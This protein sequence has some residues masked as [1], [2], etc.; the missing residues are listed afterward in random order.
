M[1]R[2]NLSDLKIPITLF[3]VAVGEK[4]NTKNYL[5]SN[6]IPEE[7]KYL[8]RGVE[9]DL[10]KITEATIFKVDGEHAVATWEVI[11][12]TPDGLVLHTWE[13]GGR[14][15]LVEEMKISPDDYMPSGCKPDL[16][17]NKHNIQKSVSS[18]AKP[19]DYIVSNSI[20][21]H[22]RNAYNFE[23]F[24]LTKAVE[25]TVFKVDSNR[26]VATWEVVWEAA[27]NLVIHTWE[28]KTHGNSNRW[29]LTN[30]VL[31]TK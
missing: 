29:T 21:A 12:E 13:K 20:P 10:T 16:K 6:S 24:D 8:Y 30:E 1:N 3:V 31:G 5:V 17:A 18:S 23:G 9:F 25:A 26:P 4:S 7:I 15:D 28:W 27:E 14:W 19:I 11:W 2:L 22:V